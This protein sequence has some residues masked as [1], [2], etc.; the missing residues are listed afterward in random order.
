MKPVPELDGVS[1]AGLLRGKELADRPLF[2]HSPH[3]ANQG[4]RPAG[5]VREG[6]WKLV[7]QYEDG[8]RELYNLTDDPGE[9]RDLAAQNPAK[10]RELGDKL[11][12]WRKAVGA[13]EN[14]PNPNFDPVRYKKLYIDV[15]VST[16]KAGATAAAMRP[17]LDA[18]RQEM[19]AVLRPAPK[20]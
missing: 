18:W 10:T 4:S 20:P 2:W 11:A 13:Q 14:T 3:Y 9:S 6:P 1:L 17:A 19:G 12:A 5:A 7:E 15:D 8:K 16:L